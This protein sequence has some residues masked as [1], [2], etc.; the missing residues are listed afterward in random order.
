MFY[1][2]TGIH[3]FLKES[4]SKPKEHKHRTVSRNFTFSHF[5]TVDQAKKGKKE[6]RKKEK[7]KKEE[8]RRG[9]ERYPC[10]TKSQNNAASLHAWNVSKDDERTDNSENDDRT[11]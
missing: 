6:K 11:M 3:T 2:L 5:F 4:A 8:K 1:D 9:E 10:K 7:G